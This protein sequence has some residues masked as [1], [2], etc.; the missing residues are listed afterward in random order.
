MGQSTFRGDNKNISIRLPFLKIE[1]SKWLDESIKKCMRYQK[2]FLKE[3]SGQD[4]EFSLPTWDNASLN[5]K[6]VSPTIII[7]KNQLTRE[8]I[9]AINDS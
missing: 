8:N 7:V 6:S 4:H 3:K 9:H 1:N 5:K 2:I